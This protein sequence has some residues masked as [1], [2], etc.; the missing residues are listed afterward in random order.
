MSQ[1]ENTINPANEPKPDF[2]PT[3]NINKI[4]GKE[5]FITGIEVNRGKP[6]DYTKPEDIGEDGLTEYRTITTEE[7]FEIEKNGEKESFN[8]FYVTP[9][10]KKQLSRYEDDLKAG[11]RFGP[12]KPVKRPKTDNPS[13]FYW[14]LANES[15][16]DY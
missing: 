2:A 9:A 5:I 3:V 12:V 8:H 16:E 6:N 11:K 10:I 15:D 1:N 14:A 13:Q 7:S 4:G